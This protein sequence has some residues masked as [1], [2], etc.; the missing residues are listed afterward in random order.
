M[1]GTKKIQAM[2][3]FTLTGHLR[4][5]IY[6][7]TDTRYISMESKW[8][9]SVIIKLVI[10]AVLLVLVATTNLFSNAF[11]MLMD[12]DN[13]I[14][15]ES[16][17]FSFDPFEINQGSSNYWIYGQDSKNYYYFSYESPSPYLFISKSNDCPV[18]NRQDY[19]TWCAAQKGSEK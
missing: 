7:V 6:R 5:L 16:S 10:V 13:F 1:S 19:T 12:R 2:I 17:I 8:S 4:K 14:P 18:F 3:I 15:A 11:M 9:R